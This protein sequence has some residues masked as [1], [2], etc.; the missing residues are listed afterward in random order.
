MAIVF[1]SSPTNGQIFSD[2]VTGNRYTYDSS[3]SLWKFSSN[4]VGMTVGT[5]PPPS[6]S[7]APGAMWYN[8][9]TGRTFILYDDG[10]SRQWV[11]NVPAVGSFDSSTVAG[12]AN[13]ASILAVAPA[14][15]KANTALQNTSG[16]FAGSL[17]V[18]GAI[19]GGS[20]TNPWGYPVAAY[21]TSNAATTWVGSVNPNGLAGVGAGFISVIH[22]TN[23]NYSYQSGA[24]NMYITNANTGGSM[25]L[26]TGGNYR[27][28]VLSGGNI[29]VGTTTPSAKFHVST[30]TTGGFALFQ[31][32]AR[33]MYL[34]DDGSAARISTEGTGPFAIRAANSGGNHF[35]IDTTGRVYKSSN[36]GTMGFVSW[37]GSITRSTGII[38]LNSISQGGTDFNTSTY[39]FTAPVTGMYHFDGTVK[40][41]GGGG[42]NFV[43][44]L[45]VNGSNFVDSWGYDAAGKSYGVQ[46]SATRALSAGDYVTL[47]WTHDSGTAT[48]VYAWFSYFI[49]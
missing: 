24:G 26:S 4:N 8:T 35:N 33:T 2:P 15:N 42:A 37:S 29:G 28:T 22:G 41:G 46:V 27:I 1:P 49:I 16:T 12:Y 34:E 36:S 38:P 30:G 10:D 17:N 44:Y 32:S 39:R 18:T 9:N 6:A 25:Y 20:G 21:G 19:A 48:I 7:V 43:V 40:T 14:F 47:Q 13:A 11:E 45:C 23:Y 31:G 5:A 3:K